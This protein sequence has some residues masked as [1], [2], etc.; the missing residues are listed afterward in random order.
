MNPAADILRAVCTVFKISHDD[1]TGPSRLGHLVRARFAA[2]LL[3]REGAQPKL[4]GT[5]S[6]PQIGRLL[7]GRDHSTIIWAHQRGREL[8]LRDPDFAQ[9]VA[10]VRLILAGKPVP[11]PAPRAVVE[12]AL[13]RARAK[14]PASADCEDE[15]YCLD[16]RQRRI[17]SAGLLAAIAREFPGRVAL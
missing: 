7:G 11:P 9:A 8:L 12:R 3:L 17:G 16:A 10:V 5:R 6:N 15:L 2:V 13:E 14:Q 4:N 1:L